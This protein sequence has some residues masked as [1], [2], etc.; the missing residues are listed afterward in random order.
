MTDRRQRGSSLLE[1]LIALFIGTLV[2]GSAFLCLHEFQKTADVLTSL[3]DRDRCLLLAPL[4]F[5]RWVAAAG[6]GLTGA[7]Q[8]LT[9]SGEVLQV[10][11]DI[12]GPDGRPDGTLDQAFEAIDIRAAG[13]SLQLRSG[14]GSFQPALAGV[15]SVEFDREAPAL[16]WIQLTA[17]SNHR[18][19]AGANVLRRPL[20]VHLWNLRPQLFKE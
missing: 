4:L 5:E 16:L 18:P 8:G 9:V 11:S 2:S 14:A 15:V 13:R 12:D 3:L 20:A 7:G 19:G 1:V 10:R 6:C 17:G